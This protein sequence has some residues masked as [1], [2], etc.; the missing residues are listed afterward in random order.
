[1]LTED[2]PWHHPWQHGLETGLHGING[3]EFWEDPGQRAGTAI[4]SIEPSAPR[5]LSTDPPDWIIDAVWRHADGSYLLIEQQR[6]TL[7]QA[8]EFLYLDFDWNLHA[9]PD[10][11]IKQ[12]SYGGFYARTAYRPELGGAVINSAGMKGGECEQQ[13]S[14]WVDVCMRLPSAEME[15]GIAFFDHPEN[16]RH[17][18][19]WRMDADFGV[20]P[21]PVI[22]GAVELASGESIRHRYR[23]LMHTGPLA[24]EIIHKQWD[25]FASDAPAREFK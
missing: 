23:I 6:W 5:I 10:V 4:G 3:C 20:N 1:M 11:Y 18:A 13:A 24:P 9:I 25:A 21:S 16:P 15:A 22:Q 14:A 2:S 12:H 19:H 8:S 7:R 17:P